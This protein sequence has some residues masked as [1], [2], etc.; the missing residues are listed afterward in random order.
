MR[1]CTLDARNAG[2]MQVQMLATGWRGLTLS[3]KVA[4]PRSDQRQIAASAVGASSNLPLPPQR[5]TTAAL[6]WQ[7]HRSSCRTGRSAANV[8]AASTGEALQQPEMGNEADGMVI[9]ADAAWRQRLHG[10]NYSDK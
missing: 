10:R 3:C 4:H 8:S 5:R 1:A 2:Y 6:H 7:R 9:T